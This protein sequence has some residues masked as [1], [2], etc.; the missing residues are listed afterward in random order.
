[1]TSRRLHLAVALVRLWTRAYTWHMPAD[2]RD[3]RRAEIESDLWEFLQ[4]AD[5]HREVVPDVHLYAR[6]LRGM[7][8]DVLWRVEHAEALRSR[9]RQRVMGAAAV[10]TSVAILIAV[11][12][13]LPLVRQDAL[14]STLSTATP[15]AS[16]PATPTVCPPPEAAALISRSAAATVAR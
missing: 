7:P 6:L 13:L 8:H 11:L 5:A 15:P 14:P 16:A 3:G 9:A 1:M 12:W 10:W 4:D 2:V